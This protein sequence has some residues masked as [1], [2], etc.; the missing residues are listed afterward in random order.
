MFAGNPLVTV[1]DVPDPVRAS[2]NLVRHQVNNL[3]K[4]RPRLPI[5]SD[6][7]AV[8]D[9]FAD[10]VFGLW[11]PRICL[12][13]LLIPRLNANYRNA[14][15]TRE[16]VR[17]RENGTAGGVTDGR[18]GTEEAGVGFAKDAGEIWATDLQ[19]CLCTARVTDS[20][21]WLCAG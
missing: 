17:R 6:I 21:Q 1:R 18:S 9:L 2:R 15:S 8:K 3:E 14:A 13:H 12:Y 16:D 19:G 4:A 7:R 10:G 11:H 20:Q 5:L